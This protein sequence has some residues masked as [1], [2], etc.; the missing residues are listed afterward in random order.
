MNQR[1]VFIKNRSISIATRHLKKVLSH[2]KINK[3][4]RYDLRKSEWC[5]GCK[6]RV[7]Q[8]DMYLIEGHTLCEDC[9]IKKGLFPLEHTGSRRD[10]I[11][12]RGRY[13]INSNKNN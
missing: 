4:R 2:R 10:K 6:K 12:E 11:S 1:L 8:N 9:A 13:L 3:S 7:P 5:T